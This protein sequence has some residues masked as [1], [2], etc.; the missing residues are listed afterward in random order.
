MG[1]RIDPNPK[2]NESVIVLRGDTNCDRLT[3]APEWPTEHLVDVK[4]ECGGIPNAKEDFLA[5]FNQLV[6]SGL[7]QPIGHTDAVRCDR[8]PA[9]TLSLDIEANDVVSSCGD[10]S[11]VRPGGRRLG[12]K[13]WNRRR[14]ERPLALPLGDVR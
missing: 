12:A 10:C 13:E 7:H 14:R 11:I 2:A 9:R 5:G 3:R 8:Y 1:S 6:L 4:R